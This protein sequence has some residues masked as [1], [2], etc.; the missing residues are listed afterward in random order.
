[1]RPD[2]LARHRRSL[3]AEAAAQAIERDR[4]VHDAIAAIE[5]EGQEPTVTAVTQRTGLPRTA[6]HRRMARLP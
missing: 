2:R 5:A 1:M 4:L 3:T 6:V